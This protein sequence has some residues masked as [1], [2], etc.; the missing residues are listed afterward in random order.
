MSKP[1]DGR[2]GSNATNGFRG[3]PEDPARCVEEVWN[4]PRGMTSS[5]CSRKRGHG[6]NN[7]WC[8]QHAKQQKEEGR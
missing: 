1:H 7:E 3:A 6:P 8:K 4:G 2:Y 5:Q